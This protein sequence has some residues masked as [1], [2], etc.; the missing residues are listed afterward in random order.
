MA[1]RIGATAVK[2]VYLGTN[3]V[4]LMYVDK[5][6]VFADPQTLSINIGTGIS[7]VT[8]TATAI[9]GKVS[10]GTLYST[11][12]LSFGYGTAVSFSYS[13]MTGYQINGYSSSVTMTSDKSVSFTATAKS[14]SVYL[15]LRY[16]GTSYGSDLGSIQ[17]STNNS[18]WNTTTGTTLSLKYGSTL[19]LRN[20]TALPGFK[21]SS[22][23]YNGVTQ[24]A[25][26]GVYKITVG[27]GNYYLAINYAAQ[28]V[29]SSIS[30]AQA[31]S[32]TTNTLT[33]SGFTVNFNINIRV[34]QCAA[35][36]VIGT[37]PLYYR[38]GSA[39][40]YTTNWKVQTGSF[41]ETTQAKITIRTDGSIVSDTEST[42]SGSDG[43][44]AKWGSYVINWYTQ[45]SI[46]GSWSTR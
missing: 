4:K 25:S 20:V 39:K 35:G 10:T 38:P 45:I 1:I 32:I 23:Q 19:Y 22:I 21:L 37:V 28:S 30:F 44:G 40:T 2:K 41:Q 7:S 6:L 34:K 11:A 5:N 9:D 29:S 8:Y 18:T 46:S 16:G 43:G 24:S 3:K 26:G 15:Q 17:Y 42:G 13:L 27:A 12:S 36:S 14:Y 33:K 31:E